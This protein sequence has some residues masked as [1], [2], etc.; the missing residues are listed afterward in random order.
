MSS[1]VPSRPARVTGLPAECG[2]PMRVITAT[3][4]CN[5][6]EFFDFVTYTFFAIYIGRAFFP[7]TDAQVSLLLSVAVFGVGFIARPLGSIVIGRYADRAGRR[8]ALVLT[9]VLMTCGTLGLATAPSHAAI[10]MAAPAIV[11]LSRLIQGFALGGEIGPSTAF[12]LESAQPGRRALYVSLQ[13]VSQ[14]VATALAGMLGLG[15]AASLTPEDMADWG[16]RIPFV[17]GALLVP[18]AL[19]LRAQMPETLDRTPSAHSLPRRKVKDHRNLLLCVCVVI[20]GTVSTYVATYMATYSTAFLKLPISAGMI[21][22]IAVGLATVAGAVLGGYMADRFGRWHVMLWPRVAAAVLTVPGFMLL[23]A[24]PSVA[25]LIAV[26]ILLAVL[27]GINGS[28]SFTTL[29]E[30]FPS[31]RRALAVAIVYSV[32]VSVFGG[33]TQLVVT[34]LTGFTGNPMTPAWYVAA[35]SAVAVFATLFLPETH[36][37]H[38]RQRHAN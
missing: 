23:V 21:A 20:G 10:G 3:V 9:A 22:T 38:R 30:L 6:L 29:C 25:T 15:L 24:Q 33:T 7:A 5:A 28:A 11:T 36:P 18:V 12:L 14:G 13:L 16:W 37:S 32:G 34:W 1:T 4:L 2:V 17:I 26:S 31:H 27:T 35:A 8:P 19:Y